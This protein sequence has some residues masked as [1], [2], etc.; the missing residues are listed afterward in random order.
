ME[1]NLAGPSILPSEPVPKGKSMRSGS[2]G[3]FTSETTCTAS[4]MTMT[5]SLHIIDDAAHKRHE[6]KDLNDKVEQLLLDKVK[7]GDTVA[8]FQLG[9]F[10]FEQV[11]HWPT[12]V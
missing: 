10:Y 4:V 5:K 1:Q 7:K 3:S 11:S 2:A 12:W 9:Q 8:T 6:E